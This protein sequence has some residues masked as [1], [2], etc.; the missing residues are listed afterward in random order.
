MSSAMCRCPGSPCGQHD[1]AVGP[2]TLERDAYQPVSSA[3]EPLLPGRRTQ[4]VT[5]QRLAAGHVQ[6]ARARG[7]VQREAVERGAQGLV[8]VLEHMSQKSQLIGRHRPGVASS[9]TSPSDSRLLARATLRRLARPTRPRVH[10]SKA[11][12]GLGWTE[13]VRGIDEDVGPMMRRRPAALSSEP[14]LR[15]GR[16]P[17]FFPNRSYDGTVHQVDADRADAAFDQGDLH[18]EDPPIVDSMFDPFA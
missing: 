11:T 9:P 12:R 3:F 2:G 4:H 16:G 14:R 6:G 15:S 8:A 18:L 17:D 10:R 7:R 13:P 1:G 5:E